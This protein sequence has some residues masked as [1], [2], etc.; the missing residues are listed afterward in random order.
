M[1]ILGIH[2]GVTLNQHERNATEAQDLTK[3]FVIA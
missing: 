1:N 3:C 2:G